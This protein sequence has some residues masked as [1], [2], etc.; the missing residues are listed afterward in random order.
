MAPVAEHPLTIGYVIDD[1]SVGGA[2]KQLSILASAFPREWR[3]V[4][5]CLSHHTEPYGSVLAGRG[6][7]VVSFRRRVRWNPLF[8]FAL[9]KVLRAHGVDV[10]HGWLDA[11]NVYAYAAARLLGAPI[12]LSIQSD[13][14]RLSGMRARI[15]RAMLRR[16]R[17]VTVNSE[18]GR[19]R[20]I[21]SVGVAEDRALL[22]PNWV[23]PG[24]PP[25]EGRESGTPVVGFVGRLV[26]L[27]RVDRLIEAFAV[28]RRRGSSARLVIVGDGP[29][30]ETL[31]SMARRGDLLDAVTFRG[32]VEDVNAELARFSC[33]VIPSEFEGLPNVALEAFAAGVPVVARPVGDLA[34][35]VRDGQTG[36]IVAG[37]DATDL[38]DTIESALADPSLLENARRAGPALIRERFPIEKALAILLPL[39]QRLEREKGR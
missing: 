32:V 1:L 24:T 11:S 28:M 16:A 26:A 25:T 14:L 3:V 33:L 23:P 6:I 21:G 7:D 13:R 22:V 19:S 31:E 30:R 38:A 34:S 29:A 27:K 10:V 8:P 36:R 20:I 18:S 5:C 37:A 4:V 12:V 9:A 15:L 39:Y 2:Q 17:A 35:L